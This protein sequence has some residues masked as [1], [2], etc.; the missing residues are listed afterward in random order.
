MWK[1]LYK[2]ICRL[3]ERVK[4]NVCALRK[5]RIK[6]NSQDVGLHIVQGEDDE[7]KYTNFLRVLKKERNG[8][9]NRYVHQLSTSTT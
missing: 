2:Y 8:I 6:K 4:S 9:V 3:V 7:G 5:F 1:I